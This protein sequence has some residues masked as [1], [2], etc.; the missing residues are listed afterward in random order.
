MKK[1][2]FCDPEKC[3]GCQICEAVCSSAKEK[4]INSLLS[5]IRLVRVD[6]LLDRTVL[7]DEGVIREQ[8]VA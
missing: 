2:V 4:K 3:N 7:A 1:V 5:R 8:D 6:P